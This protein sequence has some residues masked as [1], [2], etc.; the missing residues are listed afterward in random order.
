VKDYKAEFS[1]GRVR[2]TRSLSG[3]IEAR[4][5]VVAESGGTKFDKNAARVTET[6]NAETGYGTIPFHRT[7]FTARETKAYFNL[8][9]ALIRG[10]GLGEHATNLLI[11]LALFKVRRFLSTGLR[12]RTACDLKAVGD[13]VVTRPEDFTIPSEKDL[14]AECVEL[15]GACRAEGL[16]ADPP[17]TPVTWAVAAQRVTIDLP[18]G[19]P[20]P[21]IPEDLKKRVKLKKATKKSGPKLELSEGL[22]E[23]LAGTLKTL[24][25]GNQ[26]VADAIEDALKQSEEGKDMEDSETGTEGEK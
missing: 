16:F 1:G 15:I 23:E 20:E 9:M 19:T 4:D 11:A 2:I 24:F 26:L 22:D 7:E 18:I 14:L 12:L 17:V 25:P 6:G 5:V 10:Y 13:L 3:F 21:A 8:D